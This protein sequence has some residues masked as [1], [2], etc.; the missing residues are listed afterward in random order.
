MLTTPA[1]RPIPVETRAVMVRVEDVDRITTRNARRSAH[2]PPAGDY[3]YGERQ[4]SV[5]DPDGQGW[6]FSQSIADMNPEDWGGTP[7]RL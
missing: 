6:T 4:Y 2:R 3:P 7:G 5:A 1:A